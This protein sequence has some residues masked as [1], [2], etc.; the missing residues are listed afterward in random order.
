MQAEIALLLASDDEPD[1]DWLALAPRPGGLTVVGDPKQSIYRFRRADIAVYDA[2]RSGPLAG[3]EAQLV[4]NFRSAAGVIDWVNEVFDRVLVEEAGVQPANTALARRR[5]RARG[6]VPLGLRRARRAAR[7]SAERASARRRRASWRGDAAARSSTTAGPCATRRPAR[8][9][10]PPGAT[11]RSSSRAARGS[12]STSRR[13]RRAGV[14]V[15]AESG[16]A[17]FQRQEVRDLANLLRAIDD[18]P[19]RLALVGALRSSAFGCSDEDMFLHVAAGNRLD[20]PRAAERRRPEQ[21]ARGARRAA[22][23]ARLPLARLARAARARGA[24]AHAARRD[25]AARLRRRAVG[26]QP[27]KLADQA[28]AFSSA[29]GGGLRGLRALARPSSGPVGHH[30]GDRR[31]GDRR[32][33]APDDHA[34]VEGPRVSDR[35]AREP[36]L[37]RRA[38]TSSPCPTGARTAF[39]CASRP[40]RRSS[41][42]RAS[43]TPGA[44]RARS[45]TPSR[46][47]CSTSPSRARATI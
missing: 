40:A 22:R 27:V 25:R 7:R 10:P 18:P 29:G 32:R 6:R 14:P 24:R 42:R 4:Q 26:R 39:T 2:V 21:R 41:R 28:R 31:R 35:R 17:F 46:S 44:R 38:T 5:R 19:D 12:R 15:R 37:A 33:R 36:L 11:S 3:G 8:S 1:D 30:G 43:T 23:P 20:L 16:R 34:R 47:A 9:A 45:A 13:F